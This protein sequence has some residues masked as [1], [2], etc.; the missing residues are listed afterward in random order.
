MSIQYHPQYSSQL[1]DGWFLIQLEKECEDFIEADNILWLKGGTEKG[2]PTVLCTEDE[3]FIMRRDKCSNISYIALQLT[4][5]TLDNTNSENL[6]NTEDINII[7]QTQSVIGLIKS[8]PLLSRIDKIFRECSNQENFYPNP[9]TLNEIFLR[10]QSSIKELINYLLK[11]D[12]MVF[13]D[14]KGLWYPIDNSVLMFFADSILIYGTAKKVKFSNLT[15]HECEILLTEQLNI[16]ENL[17]LKNYKTDEKN[18]NNRL[19]WYIRKILQYPLS[20]LMVLKHF[21]LIP[22]DDNIC[23]NFLNIK[24]LNESIILKQPLTDFMDLSG[25]K[26][27]KVNFSSK[28]IQRTLA[29]HIL[30]TNKILKIDEYIKQF[31]N[32]IVSY[33]PME[34][35]ELEFHNLTL[36]TKVV[37][38]SSISKPDTINLFYGFPN[39][40][41][42]SSNPG[43]RFDILAGSAYYNDSNDSIIYCPHYTLPNHPRK[44]LAKLFQLK[45]FWHISEITPYLQPIIYT[46]FKVE[47]FCLQHCSI[48]EIMYNNVTLRYFYNR[49]LPID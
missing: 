18:E 8:P 33:I 4:H 31:E 22:E 6:N 30:K 15:L 1:K 16:Q 34:I 19:Y 37:G 41:Y 38:D 11:Y 29:L 42:H 5:D 9:K 44:R 43:I 32:M 14:S 12:T 17:E 2:S 49:N 39:L 13:C 25:I 24:I 23:A 35:N 3:T 10:T 47:S 36:D 45:K 20:I 46:N 28:Q 7:G 48:C 27:L 40:E 26:D 21:L